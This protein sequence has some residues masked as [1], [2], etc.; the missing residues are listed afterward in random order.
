[1]SKG[2]WFCIT[3][4]I[5]FTLARVFTHQPWSDEA[6]AWELARNFEFGSI[7]ESIKYQGHFFVWYFILL[8]FAKFDFAYPYSMLLIN[9]AFCFAA[10]VVLWRFAPFNSWIKGLMTFSFPFFTYYPVVARCYSIGH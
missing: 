9:W 2:F 10:L 7:L 4:W 6:N 3:F 1:M 5:I 8:P